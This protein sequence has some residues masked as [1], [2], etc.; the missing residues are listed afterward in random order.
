MEVKQ[1]F[2]ALYFMLLKLD[3]LIN[4]VFIHYIQL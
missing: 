3:Y 2:D 1:L 4:D